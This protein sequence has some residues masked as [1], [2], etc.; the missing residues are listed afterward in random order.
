MY[1][2][3]SEKNGRNSRVVLELQMKELPRDL[4][5]LY[6]R[7]HATITTQRHF[8]DLAMLI[9]FKGLITILGPYPRGIQVDSLND[10]AKESWDLRVRPLI[11]IG[12]PK[13]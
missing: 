13:S 3:V 5:G 2:E 12:I 1:H 8:L 4:M 9:L 7:P 11:G 10:L 6:R